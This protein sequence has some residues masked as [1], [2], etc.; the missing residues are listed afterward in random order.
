M[1]AA[2]SAWLAFGPTTNL[3]G[4][5][6]APAPNGTLS[7][8]RGTG[9]VSADT[10]NPVPRATRVTVRCPRTAY[11]R[12]PPGCPQGAG[13]WRGR[14]RALRRIGTGNR[15]KERS[16]EG[17]GARRGRRRPR[18]MDGRGDGP[19]H[20]RAVKL[21]S[22]CRA[23]S[24]PRP[25][26]PPAA[27]VGPCG[28]RRRRRRRRRPGTARPPSRWRRGLIARTRRAA[29]RPRRGAPAPA[30]AERRSTRPPRGD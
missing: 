2:A 10:P 19:R 1:A 8:G 14:V 13:R 25:R 9:V 5:P 6:L 28:A 16:S 3:G 11:V 27:A 20:R 23:Q 21:S 12:V 30:G 15:S 4:A 26:S 18:A 29:P 7:G 24:R 22:S 17:A